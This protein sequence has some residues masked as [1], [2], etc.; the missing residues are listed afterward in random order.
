MYAVQIAVVFNVQCAVSHVF[1][2][3]TS[4]RAHNSSLTNTIVIIS[5][6]FKKLSCIS[7]RHYH[8]P[9][10]VLNYSVLFPFWLK[11]L[12]SIQL[13]QGSC[14]IACWCTRQNHEMYLFKLSWWEDFFNLICFK[15][16]VFLVS[17]NPALTHCVIFYFLLLLS[18]GIVCDR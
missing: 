7:R 3:C 9:K 14:N 2:V 4:W 15:Q 17:S 8:F 18:F 10:N 13:Q 5:S 16:G 6:H 11:H 12:N 1:N